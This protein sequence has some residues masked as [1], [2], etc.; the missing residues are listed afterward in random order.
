MIPKWIRIALPKLRIIP[1]GKNNLRFSRLINC[2][3]FLTLLIN[4]TLIQTAKL[5]E[6]SK[7]KVPFPGNFPIS[8]I[9]HLFPMVIE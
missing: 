1:R 7:K 8:Y 6:K 2:L 4:E 3:A 5:L 9:Y